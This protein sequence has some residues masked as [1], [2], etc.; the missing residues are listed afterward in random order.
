MT[1]KEF[2]DL[3]NIHK[4]ILDGA[5][6]SNLQKRGMPTGVCPEE[7]ILENADVMC[8]LQR[9]YIQAGTNVLY[10]PTFSGNRIKLEEYGLADKLEQMNTDLVAI[11]KRAIQEEHAEGKVFIAG[12]I[13]MTGVQVEPLGPMP[14]EE[15]VSVYK[16]QITCLD[17]A[18]VDLLVVETMMSLQECRAAVI[19]AKE[20][21]TLPIMVTLSFNEDGRTLFGTNPETAALVLTTLSADAIG[22]NC[23]TGPE[24]MIPVIEKMS[25]YTDIPLIC[26]P[27][28]GLPQM[29]DGETVYDMDAD[30]FAKEML[31]LAQKGVDILGGCCGTTPEHIQKMVSAL[32]EEN[33]YDK[34]AY[35]ERI[36]KAVRRA[37]SSE[38]ATKDIDLDGAFGIIGER[39]NPTGKKALQAE[40]R[41]GCL[42]IV[43]DMAEAQEAAGASILDV[44]MGMNGI[45]EKEM[46]LKAVKELSV[47]TDLPLSIDSSHV[48]VVEAALRI[49]PGRALINSISL[50]PEKFEKLIPIAKKYGAMFILLPLSEKGLPKDIQEKKEIIHIILDAAKKQGLCKEDVIVD[51]LVA[52]VGANRLAAIETLETIS[53]CKN[54]LGVATACGLSNISFGL[55]ERI[56][57]NSAFMAMAIQNGS[58]DGDRQSVTG[59]FVHA[60]YAA[61]LLCNK[62]DSDL[63]YI[64]RVSQNKI[65]VVDGEVDADVAKKAVKKTDTGVADTEGKDALFT[66]VVKG[67][68]EKVLE[69]VKEKIAN[70][71]DAQGVIDQSLIPAINHVGELFDKQ[72]YYLPQ[73]ISSAE[74]M[75]GG[76][77]LLEPELAKN[78]SAKSLGTVVIA[79]VEHDIHDI[80]KNLV[81]LMLRNYGY[82]VIDLGKDVPADVIIETAIKEDADIIGL[83]ALMTTTMMEMKKVV[84][85]KKKQNV[86]AKVIIGGAVITQGFADEIGAD[87]YS[88]DAQD[89]V[90]VVGRLLAD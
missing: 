87:G 60:V 37:V 26:K 22:I 10:A 7:W 34:T 71:E 31:V 67:R 11:S 82:K 14:F 30:T 50:E 17:K 55:P 16:E 86:R 38:R 28:A 39:I 2:L 90:E 58:D 66:A 70:G 78:R 29:V 21:T 69:L 62:P 74:A 79:T 46:M 63:R 54:E 64:E 57:V 48:D 32:K 83:S 1:K 73:L 5:T 43:T 3:V 52:T 15:L 27:N 80:G 59:T 6:G 53:Y 23:S 42:D 40:L 35:P 47:I 88:K 77:D 19:A 33:L 24:K 44:N 41:E 18:G 45:D 84:N 81:A 20:V 12:D 76:I 65:S 13:T 36:G 72:I 68:K 51:G 89:A 85:M 4:V 56:F 9:E 61:D 49:Y 75:E 8:G 25:K